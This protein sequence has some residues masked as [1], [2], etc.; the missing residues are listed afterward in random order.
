MINKYSGKTGNA[1]LRDARNM[2]C[3]QVFI[4]AV[5]QKTF[6]EPIFRYQLFLSRLL[7]LLYY[8]HSFL[9]FSKSAL[10][11]RDTLGFFLNPNVLVFSTVGI[12]YA[13]LLLH[14]SLCVV[15]SIETVYY[16]KGV[17]N[18]MDTRYQ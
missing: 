9:P 1:R 11:I 7:V 4:V 8:Y 15:I 5:H 17:Y 12:L 16:F 3:E 13:I 2:L 18:G 14:A 10:S 6:K